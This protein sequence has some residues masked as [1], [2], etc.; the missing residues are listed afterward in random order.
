MASVT[1][2][3]KRERCFP[4]P[5]IQ[6]KTPATRKTNPPRELELKRS[7]DVR[8]AKAKAAITPGRRRPPVT[9]RSIRPSD[10]IAP[11]SRKPAV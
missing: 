10:T 5:A 2:I 1:A 6:I 8:K 9:P 4:N 3:R 11:V 7:R